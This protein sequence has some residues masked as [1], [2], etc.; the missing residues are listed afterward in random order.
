MLRTLA[1]LLVIPLTTDTGWEVLRYRG[2]P[3]HV[4]DFRSDGLRIEVDR[5]AAPIV[6]PLASPARVAGLRAEGQLIGALRTDAQRQGQRGADDYALR[7]GLVEVGTNRPGWV[8]RTMAPAWVRRLFALAPPNF[9]IAGIRFFNL[10]V[11]PTQVGR[12]RTHPASA[13]ITERIVTAPDAT[14]RFGVTVD[15]DTPIDTAAIWISADGDDTGSRFTL[16]LDRL[17]LHLT[18]R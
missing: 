2:I 9:G 15:L 11:S 6:Y 5:S 4:V 17:E 8:E 7:I 12:F 1:L 18:G 16:R 10:G 3:A 13:L 14:G